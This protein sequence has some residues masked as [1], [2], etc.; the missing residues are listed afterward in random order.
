MFLMD[1]PLSSLDAELKILLRTEI[2]EL[3]SKLKSTFVYVTHDQSEAMSL[4]T[5]LV[6]IKDGIIQQ[7]GTPYEVFIRPTNK[8][9]ASFIGQHK[10]NFFDLDVVGSKIYFGKSIIEISKIFNVKTISIG[11]RPEDFVLDSN[12]S[13]ALS[14]TNIEILGNEMLVTGKFGERF[15]ASVILPTDINIKNGDIVTLSIASLSHISKAAGVVVLEDEKTK[16]SLEGGEITLIGVNDP[17]YQTDYLFGDA[18]SV[19]NA[20]LEELHTE[21]GEFTVLLSHRPELFEKYVYHDLDLVLSGHAH[22]GQ[23]RLPFVGGLVAPNQ[24]FFP[25]YD[26]G[27][28]SM[29]HTNMIVSR[30]IGNSILPFR[31]NNRPEVIIIE[32]KK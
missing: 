28:D 20:K 23:F 10:I 22:G 24:G 31:F 32:L 3:H 6:V 12:G 26:A 4:S 17:S 1:E 29:H 9:V 14:I 21:N 5:K 18:E 2:K 16:I 11:I 8:F 7:T 19:M 13:I 25:E 15:A 30:G 27:L